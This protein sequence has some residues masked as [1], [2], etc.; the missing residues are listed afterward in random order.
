[1]SE[2]GSVFQKGGGGTNFEQSIQTAFITGLVITG[3][4]PC[5]PSNEIIEVSFQ[6]TSRGY[7]T[8]DLLVTAKS[9]L[10]EHKL[11]MQIKHDL[12]FT[13]NSE[14]FKEVLQAF[15]KDYNNT[16]IFD[17]TK[18]KLIVVKGGLTKD[19][20]N[21]FK[22]IFNW[23]NSH[24][25]EADFIN[26]VNRI[27]GKK[28]R[29]EIIRNIL[30]E[31]NG[32]VA[33]TDKE[34]WEFTKCMDVLEYD[35]LQSGSVDQ[36]YF[37]NLIKL[38]KNNASTLNEKEIWDG[39]S[40]IAATFNKDG[41]NITTE[42]IRQMDIYKNFSTEN[43]I[44]HFNAIEKLKS[45]S[46]AIVNPLRDT[47]GDVHLKRPVITDN[48]VQSIASFPITIVTGKPGVG[49]SAQVK[50]LLQNELATSSVF[51]FRADQFSQP[52]IAN[53]FSNQGV[54]IS[55]RDIFSCISLIPDKILY[56]DSFE[57]LLESDPECAF[58]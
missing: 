22:S 37:L 40:A 15:W 53:V 57:K 18:D 6:N 55:I 13:E 58:K 1:M 12:S 38:S 46:S 20:R 2:K 50:D 8:D 41:G 56:L 21:H 27:K 54:N 19:E 31:A 25:T 5:L 34:I 52:H 26:E 33:L 49:K 24:A 16:A 48:I 42:T 4:V 39:L 35:L 44:P 7:E 14:T 23:A 45:D 29:L 3:S 32:N 43:L 36:A 17:K 9:G 30:K 51:V 28:E 10:G 47:I 11:L